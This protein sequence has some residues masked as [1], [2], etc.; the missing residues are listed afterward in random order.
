MI[1]EAIE[2]AKMHLKPYNRVIGLDLGSKT[3]GIALS[4]QSMTIASPLKVIK[5][6]KFSQNL[7][8]L[9]EIINEFNR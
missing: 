2:E 5:R 6:S 7:I 1:I 4:D 8:E 9:Q 3:I